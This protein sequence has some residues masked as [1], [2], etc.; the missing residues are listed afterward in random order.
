MM[1]SKGPRSRRRHGAATLELILVLPVLL[2]MTIGLIEFGVMFANLQ[3]VALASRVGTERASELATL[4]AMTAGDPVPLEVIEAIEQQLQ[5]SC[6]DW[7]HIRLEHN[8]DDPLTQEVLE[9]SQ[10]AD[11]GCEEFALLP[12]DEIPTGRYVRLTLTVPLSE[13][14]PSG[15]TLFGCRL[16]SAEQAFHSTTIF[17]YEIGT[18]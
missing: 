14:V 5:S 16:F 7:C 12:Q 3:Q 18:P 1:D 13:V 10:G 17:R 4:P 11:C 9:S 8:A 6:I 15:L 2:L